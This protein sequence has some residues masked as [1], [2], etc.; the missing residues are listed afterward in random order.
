MINPWQLPHKAGGKFFL[1]GI[2]TARTQFVLVVLAWLLVQG[3]LL[4]HTGIQ[5]VLES[6]KYIRAAQR[7]LQTGALPGVRYFFYL[8]TTLVIAFSLKLKGGFGLAVALQLL[9]NL[10][11]TLAFFRALRRLQAAPFSALL[12]TQLLLACLPYQHWNVYLYTESLFYSASLLFFASC[13]R[14]PPLTL[15]VVGLQLACLA[16]V[17][18]SRPLGILFLPCWLLYLVLHGNGRLRLWWLLGLGAGLL[19]SAAA[20]NVILG[21]IND[22]QILKPA[23]YHYIICD[24]PTRGRHSLE[25][26]KDR[27]PLGQL[28]AYIT[29]YPAEFLSLSARR[30]QAFFLL[31]R[32]YYSPA[33]N[34]Y[35]ALLG[36]LFYLPLIGNLLRGSRPRPPY[37]WLS[38]LLIGSFALAVCL[39]CDDYHNRFLLTLVPVFL[40]CGLFQLFENLFAPTAAPRPASRP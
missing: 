12:T 23:E 30:L 26:L 15:R 7:L 28:A 11:A 4:L 34:A 17:I 18:A 27:S 5:P 16:V 14:R 32:P 38:A 24:L 21:N 25:L 3:G 37:A 39:Q 40:F 29:A 2:R 36:A 9:A 19:V 6:E 13:L 10:L 35:L 33:H 22:W 1:P 8:T 20:A 31:V